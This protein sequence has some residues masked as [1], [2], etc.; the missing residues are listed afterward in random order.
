M[1]S[2]TPYIAVVFAIAIVLVVT[3]LA[4][5]VFAQASPWDFYLSVGERKLFENGEGQTYVVQVRSLQSEGILAVDWKNGETLVRQDL[6][7]VGPKEIR[8]F[9]HFDGTQ[10]WL[11]TPA[12]PVLRWPLT[13]GNSWKWTGTVFIGNRS[14]ATQMFYRVGQRETVTIEG[15]Q[16]SVVKVIG[17]GH[18]GGASVVRER[19]YS[20]ILGLVEEQMVIYQDGK[21]ERSTTRLLGLTRANPANS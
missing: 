3:V 10:T 18:I 15:R 11:M 4:V 16:H 13:P 14:F 7:E 12:E 6:V 2:K 21:Q 5:S 19:L 1:Q 9:S 20:P 8:L 17:Y